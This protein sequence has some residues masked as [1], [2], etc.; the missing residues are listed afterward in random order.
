MF[1]RSEVRVGK[2]THKQ[3]SLKTT[4][5]TLGRWAKNH[6]V[7]WICSKFTRQRFNVHLCRLNGYIS[8]VGVESRDAVTCRTSFGRRC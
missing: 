2:Q 4:I 3:T 8:T 5:A 1:T 7:F 6:S